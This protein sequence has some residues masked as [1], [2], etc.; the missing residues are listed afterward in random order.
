MDINEA[1]IQSYSTVF[2]YNNETSNCFQQ[3]EIG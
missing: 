1:L 3:D 2:L